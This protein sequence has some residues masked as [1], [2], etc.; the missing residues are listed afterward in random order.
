MMNT[1]DFEHLSQYDPD[2]EFLQSSSSLSLLQSIL[3][4]QQCD[5][6]EYSIIDDDQDII[7]VNS[8]L[9]GYSSIKRIKA[10]R[11]VADAVIKKIIFYISLF[12]DEVT[13][14]LKKIGKDFEI[15]SELDED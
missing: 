7:S 1:S 9:M 11:K 8:S 14:Q 5:S 13:D 12:S 2:D 4:H 3:S 10:T 15:K 6:S